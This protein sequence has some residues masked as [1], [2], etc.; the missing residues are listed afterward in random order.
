MGVP[1]VIEVVG[2]SWGRMTACRNV[3]LPHNWSYTL[4]ATAFGTV[5]TG[6]NDLFTMGFADFIKPYAE[7]WVARAMINL[8]TRLEEDDPERP[9]HSI[10]F[11][12]RRSDMEYVGGRLFAALEQEF[13]PGSVFRD[14]DSIDAGARVENR[15]EAVLSDCEVVV[16]P[17]GPHWLKELNKR[18]KKHENETKVD[19]VRKELVVAL[20]LAQE[21]RLTVMPVLVGSKYLD[22]KDLTEDLQD[23]PSLGTLQLRPD[24]DFDADLEKLMQ[25]IW[26]IKRKRDFTQPWPVRE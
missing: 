11:S 20:K 2:F 18:R 3:S 5:V 26:K 8:K 15:I 1:A 21:E 12:Y 16:A 25:A 7:E 24:P 10:F 22:K 6:K 14:I 19:W 17:L 23:L 4:R 9:D 13:G